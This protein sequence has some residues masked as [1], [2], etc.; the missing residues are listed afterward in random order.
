MLSKETINNVHECCQCAYC[1]YPMYEYETVYVD[2]ELGEVFCGK[3][4]QKQYKE[5]LTRARNLIKEVLK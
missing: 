1:G 3:Y 4:C 2:D 5:H